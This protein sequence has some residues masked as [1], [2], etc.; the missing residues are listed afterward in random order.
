M[1]SGVFVFLSSF[2]F[3][4]LLKQIKLVHMFHIETRHYHVKMSFG[5]FAVLLLW[6]FL[7]LQCVQE[8]AN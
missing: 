5:G 2:I 7:V 1:I 6:K 3:A 8:S 4:H